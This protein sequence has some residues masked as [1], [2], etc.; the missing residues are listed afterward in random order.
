MPDLSLSQVMDTC[1]SEIRN[2][3]SVW[4]RNLKKRHACFRQFKKIEDFIAFL[5]DRQL[6]DYNLKDKLL[7]ILLTEFQ[8]RRNPPLLHAVFIVIF[9]PALA[10]MIRPFSG[11]NLEYS[12]IMGEAV[13][14]L[15]KTVDTF[16]PTPEQGTLA[17]TIVKYTRRQFLRWESQEINYFNLFTELEEHSQP[18]NLEAEEEEDWDEPDVICNFLE[19]LKTQ[20]VISPLEEYLLTGTRIYRRQL[21]DLIAAQEEKLEGTGYE[22]AKKKIQRAKNKIETYLQNNGLPL[23]GLKK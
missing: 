22:A 18:A 6:K 10:N 19:L 17:K 4:Y 20:G 16:K 9:C 11:K 2:G 8:S 7:Q 1:L 12:E 13:C 3:G 14:A 15:L 21:K 23:N 5:N